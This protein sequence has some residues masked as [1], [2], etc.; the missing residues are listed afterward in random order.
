MPDR[1]SYSKWCCIAV[2]EESIKK[3]AASWSAGWLF[4]DEEEAV[5]VEHLRSP[6]FNARPQG[7]QGRVS[8]A[9]I[10]SISLPPGEYGGDFVQ[11]LF[12]N[13]LDWDAHPYFAQIRGLEVSAHFFITR[14]G[15]IWQFVSVEDRAW[16]AGVSS[17]CGRTGC[18]DYSVGI[19]LEGLE[20]DCFTDVQYQRLVWLLRQIA[21]CYT[22]LRD[23][24][25]HE[26]I[27]PERKSDPGAGFDW[28]RLASAYDLNKLHLKI[29]NYAPQTRIG[30]SCQRS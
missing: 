12:T 29:T 6:N 23:V 14:V 16:H 2:F 13:R 10:H 17:W 22:S 15:Q 18:N 5:E 8:L 19:E 3:S 1:A 28:Q 7:E 27:A 20:G 21:E 30:K 4:A 11:R 25:G 9:V 24:T 26:H